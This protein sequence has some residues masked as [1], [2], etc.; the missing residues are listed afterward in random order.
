MVLRPLA[1]QVNRRF[2]WL[3]IWVAN[4]DVQLSSERE[5]S[6]IPKDAN[7]DTGSYQRSR[8]LESSHGV[9]NLRCH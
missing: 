8:K 4:T 6:L 1:L 3:S 5:I 2:P 9:P 7:R